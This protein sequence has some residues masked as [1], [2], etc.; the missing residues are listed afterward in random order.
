MKAEI[1]YVD[2]NVLIPY[3]KN[4]RKNEKSVDLVATS[5]SE[6][7]F[8]QPIVIDKDNVVV[9]GHTRL[10]AAKKLGLKEV[11]VIKASDLTKAQVKGYRLM[12]NK[13]SDFS[14]WDEDL[15]NQ[16]LKELKEQGFDITT[17]GFEEEE[18][19]HLNFEEI[20]HKDKEDVKDNEP[21]MKIIFKNKDD[22][23]LLEDD[24]KSLIKEK[25]DKVKVTILGGEI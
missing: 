11:P 4:P 12:D 13:S 10:L 9:A 1:V 22:F 21:T 24:L 14:E 3:E 18:Y 25:Y 17:A 15:L 6:Y 19:N 5:I 16:E 8:K 2:I 23:K 7:G 20:G